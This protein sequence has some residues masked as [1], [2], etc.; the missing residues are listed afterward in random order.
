MKA[1]STET[2]M[3]T[4]TWTL[5]RKIFNF[6]MAGLVIACSSGDGVNQDPRGAGGEGH[7]TN[8]TGGGPGGGDPG[9]G[10]SI[11]G[12]GGGVMGSSGG[13]PSS[14]GS[15]LGSQEEYPFPADAPDEDGYKL[16]LRYP[17]VPIPLRLAEYQA[18]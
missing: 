12:S 13:S 15:T 3:Q 10:G 5:S 9:S 16:W 18:L 11:E 7:S 14:G 17:K 6:A 4:S 2:L 1:E 8:G